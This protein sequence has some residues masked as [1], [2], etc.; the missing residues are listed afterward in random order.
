MRDL[1]TT[2]GEIV[3]G[4]CIAVGAFL[5]DPAVGF[6]TTGVALIAGCVLVARA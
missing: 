4:F 5:V 6:I 2:V 1:L 3:G